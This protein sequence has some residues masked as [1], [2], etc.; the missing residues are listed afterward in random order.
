MS[1]VMMN[2]AART[3]LLTPA[4][5]G[6]LVLALL[7]SIS[8]LVPGWWPVNVS[9]PQWRYQALAT[10]LRSAPQ[11]AFLLV[12][13]AYAAVYGGQYTI[14]RRA[15][16]AML[17]GAAVL[18]LALPL[19]ALDFMKIRRG[20]PSETIARFTLEGMRLAATSGALA[21][22]LFWAGRRGL[23]AAENDRG[24]RRRMAGEGLIVGQDE[25]PA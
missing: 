12:V 8:A 1:P 5:L 7:I 6:V 14:V 9:D 10:F 4:V 13:I 3:Q 21:L 15:G 20:Q 19:F 17:A 2:P 11:F 23:A 18:L 25:T 24:P 22:M 16:I